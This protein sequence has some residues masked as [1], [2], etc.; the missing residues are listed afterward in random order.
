VFL[1][2]SVKT[3]VAPQFSTSKQ[4]QYK[5]TIVFSAFKLVR[6]FIRALPWQWGQVTFM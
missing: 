5:S 1:K 3:K 4:L 2:A 6:E